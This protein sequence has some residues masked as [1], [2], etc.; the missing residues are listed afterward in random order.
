M[1]FRVQGLGFRVSGG[2]VF[3]A[4]RPYTGPA[5]SGSYFENVL[6]SSDDSDQ[7]VQS[8]VLRSFARCTI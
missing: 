8:M 1:G 2:T 7:R 5:W 6:G 3:V 4:L